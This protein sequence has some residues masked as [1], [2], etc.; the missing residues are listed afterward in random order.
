MK[1]TQIASDT[2]DTLERG[3]YKSPL[4]QTR[5]IHAFQDR[6]AQ[7]TC[8]YLPEELETLEFANTGFKTQIAVTAEST[9]EAMHRLNQNNLSVLALNFA[10]ARNPGGGFLRGAQAQE[11]SLARSSGLYGCLQNAPDFYQYHRHNPDLRYSHRMIYSPDVPFFK[12]D[13]GALLE[14]P[15]T[16]SIITSA[17]PNY[18]ALEQNQPQHLPSVPSVLAARAELVLR[19]AAHHQHQH[20]VLGAWGCGVFKNPPHLVARVF[21]ELLAGVYSG[22]FASVTFAVYDRSKSQNVVG[23][24]RQVFS[25]VV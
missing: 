9:L 11:E 25:E 7:G 19:L 3:N 5:D 15:Y 12:N 21:L 6:A 24:F 10:S 20:L 22:V 14:M 16:A 4:G 18:G 8:F 1:T 13:D 17:A 23:A 2:V